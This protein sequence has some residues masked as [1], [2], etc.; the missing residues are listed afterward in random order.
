ML[1]GIDDTGTV[2]LGQTFMV[3][4]VFIRS[5][6]M[7]IVTF[8]FER[9]KKLCRRKI[10]GNLKEIKS[11]DLTDGMYKNFVNDVV[12]A[13][14]VSIWYN[15]FGVMVDNH[16][17]EWGKLQRDRFVEQY[18]AEI[19]VAF[20]EGRFKLAKQTENLAGWIKS[21]PPGMQIKMAVLDIAFLASINQAI[22]ESVLGKFDEELSELQWYIDLGFLKD[23]STMYWKELLRSGLIQSSQREPI[24][25]ITEWP[26]DHPFLTTF[27]EQSK[28][29]YSK[30][31]REFAKRINFY[32]SSTSIPVQLADIFAGIM[33]KKY[34]DGTY[35]HHFKRLEEKILKKERNDLHLLQFSELEKFNQPSPSDLNIYEE[36]ERADSV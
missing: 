17:L 34:L 29:P 15:T 11:T 27:I 20:S 32:D 31:N 23:K 24:I 22:V 30:F 1:I 19:P 5:T 33:R 18:R 2:A 36:F 7:P 3:S 6:S 14:G 4:V 16:T 25:Q 12:F 26:D 28:G 13:P 10:P 8:A 21:T 9:W 35:K